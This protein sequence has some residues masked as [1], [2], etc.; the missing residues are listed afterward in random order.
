MAGV[1]LAPKMP[2][3]AA[4][5]ATPERRMGIMV[6]TATQY[7]IDMMGSMQRGA[8]VARRPLGFFS[9]Q[10]ASLPRGAAVAE[11][12]PHA[13]DRTAMRSSITIRSTTSHCRC[14][15]AS[16]RRE[17]AL[18]A[19]PDPPSPLRMNA[20]ERI[21][22]GFLAFG[23]RVGAELLAAGALIPKYNRLNL[24]AI[25]FHHRCKPFPP[26]PA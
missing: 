2:H 5:V 13:R 6:R 22:D 18:K 15:T 17:K 25:F 26:R 11:T 19:F 10:Y 14:A 12:I 3:S 23:D 24:H 9:M 16:S 21:H 7:V 1:A 8:R 4:I 20:E